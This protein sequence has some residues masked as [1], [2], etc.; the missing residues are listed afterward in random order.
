MKK[1]AP[2]IW[3]L[4]STSTTKRKYFTQ[5]GRPPP[6]PELE[7]LVLPLEALA[8]DPEDADDAEPEEDALDEEPTAA[9]D[10]PRELPPPLE[11]LNDRSVVTDRGTLGGGTVALAGATLRALETVS[12][13]PSRPF[14]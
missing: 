4:P 13:C 1:K 2:I 12:F 6:P 9:L 11:S 7:L 5:C 14:M 10:P 8:L 3:G